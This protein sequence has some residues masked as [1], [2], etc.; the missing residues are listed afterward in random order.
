MYY[1]QRELALLW[2]R[3]GGRCAFPDCSADLTD[4]LPAANISN[5]CHIVARS[6]GGPRWTADY[7]QEK[8]DAYEN[9]VLLCPS[10]HASVDLPTA[11][12]TAD[13]LRA[14]KRRHED[15]VQ[16]QLSVGGTWRCNV[17]Q[18]YYVNVPRLA[19]LAAL[20]GRDVDPHVACGPAGL[21]KLAIELTRLL[22]GFE[23]VIGELTTKA[24]SLGADSTADSLVVGSTCAF[25]ARF[26]TRGCPS[27]ADLDSGKFRL[28]GDPS[29]DPCIYRNFGKLR[30]ELSVDPRW[31]TTSTSFA[32]FRDG[33]MH[34]AGLAH[35]KQ[36]YAHTDLVRASPMFLGTPKIGQ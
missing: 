2:A 13:D 28:L 25:S 30:L 29:K 16:A 19:M 33:W 8:L 6:T 12:V 10:H 27:P 36:V 21:H 11:G 1:R 32:T 23:S 4:E 34:C 5:I 20:G 17:E 3:S 7:P 14:M 22:V 24:V 18:L 15:H 31:I 9:L 26:R 35:I